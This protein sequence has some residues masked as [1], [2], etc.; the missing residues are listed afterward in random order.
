MTSADH[1]AAALHAVATESAPELPTGPFAGP[2]LSIPFLHV[3][4]KDGTSADVQTYNEDAML[5][6][7]TQLKHR[8][9]GTVAQT[10]F[11]W[12]TFLAWAALTREERTA[13]PYEV[14]RK[15]V[16]EVTNAGEAVANPTDPV[17]D[18]DLSPSL[19]SP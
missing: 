3:I 9:V 19:P 10:P 13:V 5:Y 4:Y 17:P 15:T 8:W 16:A 2:K 1:Y 14:W 7:E 11:R 12:L 6:E 18:T